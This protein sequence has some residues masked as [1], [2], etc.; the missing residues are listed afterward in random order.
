MDASLARALVVALTVVAATPSVAAAQSG[1]AARVSEARELF[2]AGSRAVDEGRWADAVSLFSRSYEISGVPPALFN[3]AFALRALGR[4]VEAKS[5]FDLLLT[6]HRDVI[7]PELRDRAV[8]LLEE[9]RARIAHVSVEGLANDR[10]YVLHLDGAMLP[11][12]RER[13]IRLEVDPGDHS[14]SVQAEG[15]RPFHWQRALSAGDEVAVHVSL[16]PLTVASSADARALAV[17][18]PASGDQAVDRGEESS[19]ILS[20]PLFWTGVVVVLAAG[21][22]TAFLLLDRE[23]AIEPLSDRHYR[24]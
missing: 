7:E 9:E 13:P 6:R 2:A 19:S 18:P 1:G 14:L 10:E 24:L 23:T 4:H 16:E 11:D 22:V 3:L 20:S 5:A 15:F 17:V 8:S 12:R 21:A